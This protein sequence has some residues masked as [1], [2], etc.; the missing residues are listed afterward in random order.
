MT[1]LQADALAMNHLR[2]AAGIAVRMTGRRM[3]D[4]A[5]SAAYVGLVVA[6]RKF[7][8]AR[9]CQF[10]TFSFSWIRGAVRRE[11][12]RARPCGYSFVM[13]VPGG[14]P[15]VMD[16]PEKSPG[17][18]DVVGLEDD[19]RLVRRLVGQLEPREAEV[20]RLLYGLD[21]N[22]PLTGEEV[23][24]RLKVTRQM[25]ALLHQRALRRL[26]CGWLAATNARTPTVA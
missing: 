3:Q 11:L 2:W 17:P 26:R 4:D 22:E 15:L 24:C 5:I 19:R 6:A 23:G 18:A 21:G 12:R 16:P 10:R 14:D 20:L 13:D 1:Q 25:V 7:N 8:V 9:D